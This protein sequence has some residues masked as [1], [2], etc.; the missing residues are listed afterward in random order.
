M[1]NAA[2]QKRVPV[3]EG[4]DEDLA[5][6]QDEATAAKFIYVLLVYS[7]WSSLSVFCLG[8]FF[9]VASLFVGVFL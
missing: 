8:C 6:V 1:P 2:P 5:W 4:Q 3:G 9:V 7:G